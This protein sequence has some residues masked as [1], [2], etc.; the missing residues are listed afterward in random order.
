[1]SDAT[2]H[3]RHGR[4]PRLVVLVVV[5]AIVG[6]LVAAGTRPMYTASAKSFVSTRASSSV[7]DLQQGASVAQQA[8]RSYA[9]LA[10]KAYVLDGVIADLHLATTPD[11][12]AER[13]TAETSTDTTVLHVDV[14]DASPA[15]AARIAN[16]VQE[17]LGRAV[18][19]LAPAVNR[20]TEIRAI[21]RAVP[22]AAPSSPNALVDLL[23]G[24][25][26]GAAAWLLIALVAAV[27]R[28]RPGPG[29]GL[30]APSMF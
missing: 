21:Q 22:P 6:L 19:S 8:S 26:G 29:G 2:T 11:A 17:H 7:G 14:T 16:A 4:W 24:A 27:R 9:M 3:G 12:L 18:G 1:M 30:A 15:Q 23:L 25:L 28:W 20:D 10:T 13:I 5:G